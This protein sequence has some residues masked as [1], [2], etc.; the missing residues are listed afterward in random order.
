MF[1]DVVTIFNYHGDKKNASAYWYPTVLEGVELQVGKGINISKS[2][3]E[4][5]DSAKLHIKINADIQ[6]AYKKPKEYSALDDKVGCFTLKPDDFFMDGAF[7]NTPINEEDY[8]NGFFEYMKSKYDDV[9]N[10]TTVDV[11]KTIPHFE[12]GGK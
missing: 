12:V 1:T 2:G 6:K 7:D 5:A 4:S 9:Y 11:F 10:I 8:P 3:N